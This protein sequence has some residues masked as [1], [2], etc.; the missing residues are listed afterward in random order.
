MWGSRLPR[1]QTGRVGQ[2]LASRWSLGT[3]G[4]YLQ[5]TGS[6]CACGWAGATSR[7][8]GCA[9]SPSSAPQPDSLLPAVGVGREQPQDPS[10]PFLAPLLS[11][12]LNEHFV[13]TTDFLDAIK[14]N[15]DKALGKQ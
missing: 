12:K 3:Q 11:V 6:G 1:R 15:L 13:N 14:N 8:Q 10:S 5:L 4:I 9:A 2:P 7:A